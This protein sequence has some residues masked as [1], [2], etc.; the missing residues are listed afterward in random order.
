[1]NTSSNSRS[2]DT[3]REY[4]DELIQLHDCDVCCPDACHLE[5]DEDCPNEDPC[6]C[7]QAMEFDQ[8]LEVKERE[9]I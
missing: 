1:M 4:F 7:F 3:A 5:L 6:P 8:W 2:M 9:F